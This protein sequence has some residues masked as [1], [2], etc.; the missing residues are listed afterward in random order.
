MLHLGI[1]QDIVYVQQSCPMHTARYAN[2]NVSQSSVATPLR[3]GGIFCGHVFAI[4]L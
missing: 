4:V 1:R 2:I 3:Y